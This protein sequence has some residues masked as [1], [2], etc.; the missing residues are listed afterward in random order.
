MH[1]FRGQF[2][3]DGTSIRYWANTYD[4]YE[5]IEI[6]LDHLLHTFAGLCATLVISTVHNAICLTSRVFIRYSLVVVAIETP[7]IR[8]F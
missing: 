5:H 7:L 8:G 3:I 4:K 6:S 2:S 1:W